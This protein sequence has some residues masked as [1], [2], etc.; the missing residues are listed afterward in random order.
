MKRSALVGENLVKYIDLL[1]DI[2]NS[3]NCAVLIDCKI[4]PTSCC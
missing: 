2:W 4:L 1:V 3:G